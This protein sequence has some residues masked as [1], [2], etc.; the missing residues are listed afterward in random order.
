MTPFFFGNTS[1]HFK[2]FILFILFFSV[3]SGC[4]NIISNAVVDM[5][6]NLS[7]AILDN[8]DPET[9]EDGGP[10]YLL[11]IDGMI[12]NDPDNP[13]LLRSAATT[14]S[15]Y[16]DLFVSSRERGQKLSDKALEYAFR[17]LCYHRSD[18]CRFRQLNY[19]DFEKKIGEMTPADMT[20][21][22]VVGSTWAGWIQWHRDDMNA[23]AEISRIEAIMKKILGMDET[24]RNG[25]AHLYLGVLNTLLPPALG[26]RPEEAR[27]HF[28][29]SIE[30]SNGNN[31]YAKVIFAKQYARL[32]FDRDLHDRLLNEVIRSDAVASG[33]TLINTMAKRQA[34]ELLKSAEDYF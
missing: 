21:L 27:R 22:Y 1:K 10:A 11:M 7:A 6:D 18:A 24:Y 12:R 15:A 25:E 17:A 14:Y 13:E 30:I 5:T 31:L 19:R 29:R 2:F 33:Y 26:G 34:E 32:V 20:P 3:F 16:T 8:D 28:E 9:V 23:I 4:Q